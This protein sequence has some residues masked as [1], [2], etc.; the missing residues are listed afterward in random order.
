MASFTPKHVS[1]ISTHD[2]H[3]A[4][5]PVRIVT[6]GIPTLSGSTVLEKI[7]N[8]KRQH[9][10]FR[11]LLMN[12]PRGHKD[13]Y[14][15]ILMA[16]ESVVNTFDVIFLN[17]EG[18]STMCGHAIIA[19]GRYVVDSGLVKGIS[20]ETEVTFN[21]P[22]GPVKTY[23]RYDGKEVTGV[24]FHSVPAFVFQ[25]DIDV[26]IPNI[27]TVTIDIAFGGAFYAVVHD[28]QIGLSLESSTLS[29]LIDA[30]SSVTETVKKQVVL[31]HPE[32]TDLAFLYGTIITDGKDKYDDGPT[33]NI[34]VF[35]DKEVDRSPTGSGVTA[36]IALQI[37]KNQM[38][39][40]ETKEFRSIIN[41][42]FTGKAIREVKFGN[43]D[44]VIVEVSGMAYHT[45]SHIFYLEKNDPLSDGFQLSR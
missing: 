27:G 42:S 28:K 37:K 32:S 19:L 15:A 36:R 5:E 33:K 2:M 14:G 17:N 30:A 3:T 10:H 38:S 35:A 20:P 11:K 43:F 29:Q 31:S 13:M 41:T 39:L 18:Y 21:C 34:C 12:E 24:H 25:Q 9:D 1:S 26:S 40:N 16:K 8:M 7:Q 23:V 44:A 22:C 4:G 6:A 45:G